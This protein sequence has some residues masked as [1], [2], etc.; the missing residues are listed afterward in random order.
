MRSVRQCGRAR[1]GHPPAAPGPHG[2]QRPYAGPFALWRRRPRMRT[3]FNG[4]ERPGSERR[5]ALAP[6]LPSD[7]YEATAGIPRLRLPTGFDVIG[8]LRR[9]AP[10]FSA[11]DRTAAGRPKG[12]GTAH[13]TFN[14]CGRPAM[15]PLG[16]VP[17]MP[18]PALVRGRRRRVRPVR[19]STGMSAPPGSRTFPG[20]W[21]KSGPGRSGRWCGRGDGGRAHPSF[22]FWSP[23]RFLRHGNRCPTPVRSNRVP[24]PKTPRT[25]FPMTGLSNSLRT[26]ATP[27]PSA[28]ASRGPTADTSGDRFGPAMRPT[29]P[30][31]RQASV[32]RSRRHPMIGCAT[33]GTTT[34]QRPRMGLGLGLRKR[35][36][37]R[38]PTPGTGRTCRT[39]TG[40]E[41][42][43]GFRASG[44]PE[45]RIR[46]KARNGNRTG[47]P[48]GNGPPPRLPGR[49]PRTMV[50][51]RECPPGDWTGA[52]PPHAAAGH[53]AAATRPQVDA[54]AGPGA[55]IVGAAAPERRKA[56]IAHR[57]PGVAPGPPVRRRCA[58]ITRRPRAASGISPPRLESH[59]KAH[60]DPIKSHNGN[61]CPRMPPLAFAPVSA[62]I[63]QPLVVMADRDIAGTRVS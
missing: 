3:R 54:C 52:S 46:Q 58:P 6:D 23:P 24:P 1:Q 36:G 50:P 11:F 16:K 62:H 30:S 49:V 45:T 34:A 33:G 60:E 12:T 19:R 40:S 39:A 35:P 29:V 7:G 51:A 25:M 2:R 22:P 15:V 10:S 8:S 63:A 9:A 32:S 41:C 55:A 59:V 42:D 17:S 4:P 57:I 61:C 20:R 43:V 37:S 26:S 13:S 53:R 31:S 5:P 21:G 27:R 44:L 48:A 14:E 47:V 28:P 18:V 38:S 56:D